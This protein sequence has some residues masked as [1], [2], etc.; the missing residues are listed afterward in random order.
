M[1]VKWF[2][3]SY[4]EVRYREHTTR[5]HGGVRPDRCYS[6]RYKIDGKDKE[7]VVDWSSEGIAQEIAFKRLSE[8]RENLRSGSGEP[9]PWGKSVCLP[10]QKMK[11][12]GRL[13]SAKKNRILRCVSIGN[14]ATRNTHSGQRR[15]RPFVPKM[16]TCGCGFF[17]YLAICHWYK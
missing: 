7:E 16:A 12:N 8:L 17:P 10:K 3:T 9:R 4:L 15:H 2:K 1:A 13:N 5:K 14:K 11:L 6:I